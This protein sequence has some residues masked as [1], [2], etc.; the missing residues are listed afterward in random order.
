MIM[1][2]S[3]PQVSRPLEERPLKRLKMTPNMLSRT[4]MTERVNDH[5]S[6]A[7]KSHQHSRG[8]DPQV[9]IYIGVGP[10]IVRDLSLKDHI[11]YILVDPL[12]IEPELPR[13]N[14]QLQATTWENMKIPW[15]FKEAVLIDDTHI[16]TCDQFSTVK[17]NRTRLLMKEP[18]KTIIGALWVFIGET[19]F[20]SKRLPEFGLVGIV[21]APPYSF[22]QIFEN[23]RPYR[24]HSLY[25]FWDSIG[26]NTDW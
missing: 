6:W 26:P 20:Y 14:V 11:K 23:S 9:V 24:T 12:L 15:A 4:E 7:I 18:N 10:I 5:I 25:A 1:N 22:S 21:P 8:M 19:A 16:E 13:A 3:R 2:T 17:N